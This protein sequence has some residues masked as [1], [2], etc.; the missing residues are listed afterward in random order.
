MVLS[1]LMI[2][3]RLA[4][5]SVL[6]LFLVLLCGARAQP[7][8]T[9]GTMPEDYL[10]E[11]KELLATAF[12]RSPQLIAAQFE[13]EVEAARIY[14]ARSAMLPSLHGTSEF[15]S[16][17]TSPSGNSGAQ[18]RAS[19]FFYRFEANQALFHWGALKNQNDAAKLSLLASQKS[20]AIVARELSV[21]LRKAYLALIV[22]RAKL[23][24]GR[25]A[26]RVLQADV[27][28]LTEKKTAGIVS[29][30]TLEGEKLRMRE[31]AADL[32]RGEADFS[33]NRRRFAR[34]VG[35]PDL[36]EDKIA[37]EIPRPTYSGSL[38]AAM[39]A[40]L[41]RDGAKTT[42]EYEVYDLRV[43]QATLRY[44]IERTR[45]L[46]K[47]NMG[48][49]Y[50]LEN[51]TD[52]VG[53]RVN[54][55]AFQRQSVGISAQWNMFDGLATRGA[56]REALAAKRL[57]ERNLAVKTEQ[58]LQDAQ[59]LERSLKID[60]DQLDITDVRHGMAVQGYE[61]IAQEAKL[62]NLARG[63]VTRAELNIMQADIRSFEARALYL[64][65]W[66]EFVAL[67]GND[68]ILAILS[69]RHD[70]EKK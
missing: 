11:L 60:A 58:T 15:S 27:Q 25:Q 62:G 49:G 63:N 48:A 52:V 5:T 29:S 35:I 16:N 56:I 66:S 32:E 36:P 65:R 50:S 69:A 13:K 43:R 67:A 8:D 23:Q 38:A 9:A 51:N 17:Q 10:P 12:Q 4:R 42:L 20:Y 1:G 53:D 39:G 64:G 68:P 47:F 14:V 34:L 41:L 26:L 24:Q 54:Q 33:A 55:Q 45:Q 70:P 44:K 28:I 61:R 7:M 19:G 31:V 30:A 40:A 22:E 21:L 37:K 18:S 59:L 6:L 2:P 3:R 46:P 57:Q